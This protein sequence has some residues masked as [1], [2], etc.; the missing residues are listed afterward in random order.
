MK[1]W[2]YDILGR[3]SFR[4]R[5]SQPPYTIDLSLS[6][7]GSSFE[8]T[9]GV[10]TPSSDRFA[11]R[12]LLGRPLGQCIIVSIEAEDQAVDGVKVAG[13]SGFDIVEFDGL[14]SLHTEGT[15]KGCEHGGFRPDDGERSTRWDQWG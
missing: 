12:G 5:L 10:Q 3:T 9:T 15:D 1:R 2:I 11:S 13:C 7:F 14:Q 4:S 8:V 6:A